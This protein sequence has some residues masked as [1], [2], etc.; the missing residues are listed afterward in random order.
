MARFSLAW[1][2]ADENAHLTETL[3]SVRLPE[4]TSTPDGPAFQAPVEEWQRHR[5]GGTLTADGTLHMPPM[6][7]C[8]MDDRPALWEGSRGKL[9]TVRMR[10]LD[11]ER[12]ADGNHSA[13]ELWIGGPEPGTSALLLFR[14][15]AVAFDASYDPAFAIDAASYHTYRV[16][17]D[18]ARGAAYLFVDDGDTPVLATRL[19][20]PYGYNLNRILF[21]DSGS[22][23]DVSGSSEWASVRWSDAALPEIPKTEKVSVK[24][25]TFGDSTTAPRGPLRIYTDLLR[26]DLPVRGFDAVVVNAGV[27]GN[28]TAMARD[29]FERDVLA[30]KP[31]IVTISFGINDSAIDIWK[32]VT[33]PRVTL[34][35]YAANLRYF[36]ATLRERGAQ[37][38]LMTPNPLAWTGPNRELYGKPPYDVNDPKGFDAML[39]PYVEKVREIAQTEAV[40]LADVHQAFSEYAREHPIE[41]L[42]LDGVHPNDLGHRLI[43]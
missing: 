2:L 21:G 43:A 6:A 31:D 24:I 27:G 34:E 14:E 41:E 17:T 22:A 23:K 15:D 37:P 4:N 8:Y 3:G 16:L 26:E 11:R 10:I 32:D 39:R 13:A 25:V 29:R 12:T 36:I 19:G 1:L 28:S 33:E 18:H 7:G 42:L 30:L 40:P 5:D 9:V 35:A 38:I 20:A